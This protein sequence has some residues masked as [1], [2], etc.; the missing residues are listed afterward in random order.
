M[1]VLILLLIAMAVGAGILEGRGEKNRRLRLSDLPPDRQAEWAIERRRWKLAINPL[2]EMLQEDPFDARS[3][4]YLGLALQKRQQ[5][6]ESK[7]WFEKAMDFHRYRPWCHYGLACIHSMQGDKEAALASLKSALDLGVRT[8]F[9]IAENNELAAI[10]NED[11]FR[12]LMRQEEA[13]RNN[14]R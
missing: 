3:M 4:Y 1:G 5:Y 6:D 14:R 10:R 12:A 8:R 7:I 2:R 13:N 9:G 11:E